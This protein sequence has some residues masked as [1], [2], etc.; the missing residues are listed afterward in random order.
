MRARDSLGNVD[1]NMVE[2]S[3]QPTGPVRF[4]YED[5]ETRSVSDWTVVDGNSDG[6]TWTTDNPLERTSQWWTGTFFIADSG[7]ASGEMDE[8][9]IS[10]QID[11][12][13]FTDIELRF[14]YGHVKNTLSSKGEAYIKCGDGAWSRE[15]RTTESDGGI[16]SVDLPPNT[17][18]CEALQ[19]KFYYS[20]WGTMNDSWFG[21][22]NIEL[23]GEPIGD[24]FPEADFTVDVT[25]GV[26][27]LEVAFTD[28]SQGTVLSYFWDFGDGETADEADP[29]HTYLEPGTYTVSLT[30][31][32]VLGDDTVVKENYIVV[33]SAGDDDD[34]TGRGGRG[35][36]SESTGCGC[37]F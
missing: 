7:T 2:K 35:S 21:V 5:F 18:E 34:D 1:D 20:Q 4:Y 25:E 33:E 9:L 14:G 32:G 24:P 11:A 12:S 6:A 16:A 28:M 36:E 37:S 31:E 29:V 26:A 17:D 23:W 19:I 30:V 3:A 15:F 22:D 10:P 13:F 8:E 27:P